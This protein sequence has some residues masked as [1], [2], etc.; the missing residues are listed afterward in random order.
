MR[1][2]TLALLTLALAITLIS[3]EVE[4]DQ[5]WTFRMST[6]VPHFLTPEASY[7]DTETGRRY[8][9]NAKVGVAS[10]ASFG[11]DFPV[12]DNNK[13]VMGFVLGT[14]GVRDGDY[15]CPDD[16]PGNIGESF[17]FAFG[18]GLAAA[19]DWERVDGVGVSY[20]YN[21]SEFGK[22]GW[23]SRFE[24]GYGKGADSKRNLAAGS[25]LIGY[26]F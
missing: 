22:S 20:S 16:E 2:K 3:T 7:Y 1:M 4:A 8:Y 15:Q 14:V 6:G 24:I 21:F 12:S 10:G 5:G 9:G 11:V 26:E 17:G 23:Y 18:C 19:F 25:I 13:H